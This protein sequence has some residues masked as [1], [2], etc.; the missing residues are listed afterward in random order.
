[1]SAANSNS[2]GRTSG[3]TAATYRSRSLDGDVL[4]WA[5]I[6]VRERGELWT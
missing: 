4:E 2:R 1:M 5:R 3:Q 6:I